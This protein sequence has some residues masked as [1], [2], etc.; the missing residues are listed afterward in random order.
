[1]RAGRPAGRL[2][3]GDRELLALAG[4]LPPGSARRDAA[5]ELLVSRYGHLV[6]AAVLA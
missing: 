6:R 2:R 1:M 3:T 5:R 4:S